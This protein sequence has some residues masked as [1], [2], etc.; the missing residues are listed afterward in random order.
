MEQD[1]YY[2]ATE[3]KIVSFLALV[4]VRLDV[5]APEEQMCAYNGDNFIWAAKYGVDGKAVTDAIDH[6][7]HNEIVDLELEY[8]RDRLLGHWIITGDETHYSQAFH[9]PDESD[10]KQAF[11]LAE[12]YLSGGL[13]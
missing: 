4:L 7:P 12:D 13:L 5:V 9:F 8:H 1:P 6:E 2:S 3:Q 10:A 11:E